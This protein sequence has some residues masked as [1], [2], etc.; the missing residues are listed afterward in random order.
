[1]LIQGESGTGKELI[2]NAIHRS[3]PRNDQRF[4]SENC[5]ALSE[6]LLESELFGH[7]RG[8]FTGAV[9]ERK[10]LFELA[11]GGTLFLDEVGDMSLSMQK[12]LLRVLEEGEIRRVGGKDTIRVDVRIIS[13]SNQDLQSL[14]KA[15]KFREDLFYRLNGIRIELPPLRER[16]EDIPILIQHFLEQI[17]QE[18]RQ[19]LKSISPEALR[20]LLSYDWPG[21]VR[22][23]RHFLER[24]MLLATGSC[25]EER[26]CLFDQVI[27]RQESQSLSEGFLLELEKLPMRQARSGFMKHYLERIYEEN[28]RNVTKAARSCG[29]SRESLHRLLKKLKVKGS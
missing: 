26:D 9:T 16:K 29:I 20:L 22:E 28:G 8:A 17:A 4:I 27:F 12:K 14:V 10:G 23:L 21:N 25:I 7:T 5:A 18:S 13:A 15:E 11:H 3:S 19:P 1:V 24:T 2:A 6:T